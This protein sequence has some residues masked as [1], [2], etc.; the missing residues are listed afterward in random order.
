M[1]W[2]AL[3]N[4]W[5]IGAAAWAAFALVVWFAGEAVGVGELRPLEAPWQR[6]V[7]IAAAGALW[8]GWEWL[9]ARRA[10]EA[11][12]RM[13]DAI[14]QAGAEGDS[15]ARAAE[16][17][18]TLRARFVAASAV[19]REARFAGPGGETRRLHELPWYVF[20]GAPGSGK[21]TALVN[22]GLRFLLGG[23]DGAP[24]VQGVGGTRNCDWWFTDEA[25]LLDTAGRYTTQESDRKADA[26]AWY[27]F[28]D[29]LK[30]FRPRVP[31]NGAIVTV[32]VS[33]L[34][35]WSREE[36]MRYAGHVR[37]RLAELYARLGSRFP[38]YVMVTKADLLAGF[39][40]FFGDLDAEGRA[41]VWG[42]TFE[43]GDPAAGA[44]DAGAR[45]EAE[46]SALER[47]LHALLIERLYGEPDL[48]R[49]AAIYRFPQQL[50]ALGP[51]V[52]E[53]V[54][55]AFAQQQNHEPPMLRGVYFTSGT[56]EGNP[57]D[58]VLGA[59]ARSF[60]LERAPA[61]AAGPSG[62]AFF[63]RRLLREVI[64]P[65]QGLAR[66]DVRE[67][68]WRPLAYAGIA[69][70]SLV[71]AAGWTVSYLGNRAWVAEAGAAAAQARE[72]LAG[73]AA[74]G[75]AGERPLAE[76][77]DMLERIATAEA[78]LAQRFG[79]SQHEKIAAQARR[80]YRAALNDALLP[81]VA[82]ALEDA[83]R[84]ATS[85][86][87]LERALA[88]YVALHD[89]KAPDASRIEPALDGLWAGGHKA[90]LVRHLRASLVEGPP[91]M[92]RAFDEAL[93]RQART[94]LAAGGLS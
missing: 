47:R 41:R 79:L 71:V 76:A 82:A 30:Q 64:F 18:A 17:I 66:D 13:L 91:E 56:Q 44:A 83:L 9:R 73:A 36:R 37:M 51:L 31:L 29:L 43:Q 26:A 4:R 42:I 15:A 48:Q 75:E 61:H 19:L 40:D 50:H 89:P 49:R 24:A 93:V 3:A 32:S 14:A 60:G 94:R 67:R 2:R 52:A 33:D 46:L 90:S 77:L 74:P 53:F 25:V 16:E 55:L 62:K 78:P 87:A 45:F 11:A 57:I 34:L 7:L 63:I 21:T 68:A 38:V 22:S 6:V 1:N 92:R 88:A 39:M 5:T 54:S 65:E 20:I 72:R 8:L 12:S 58:R 10:R 85:R 69:A 23:A 27:G 86:A 81:R 84:G 28:L 35:L 70:A 59:L 80:A